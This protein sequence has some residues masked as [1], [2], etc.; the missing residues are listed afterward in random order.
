[1]IFISNKIWKSNN[2]YKQKIKHLSRIFFEKT[3]PK[4]IKKY[5][6]RNFEYLEAVRGSVNYDNE[7]I[8]GTSRNIWWYHRF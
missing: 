5:F 6:H 8:S 2:I 4:V 7:V 3:I 1:M